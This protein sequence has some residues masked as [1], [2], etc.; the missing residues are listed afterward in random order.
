MQREAKMA[1]EKAAKSPQ[2]RRGV[3]SPKA[4]MEMSEVHTTGFY[5]KP[6]PSSPANKQLA[7]PQVKTLSQQAP[8]S[9]LQSSRLQHQMRMSSSRKNLAS[10]GSKAGSEQ[11]RSSIL[12]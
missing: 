11:W 2:G 10:P 9:R 3:H 1:A 6:T 5:I 4:D 12:P 7:I 8:V